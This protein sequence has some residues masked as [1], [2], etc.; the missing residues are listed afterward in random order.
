MTLNS[1][2]VRSFSEADLYLGSKQSRPAGNN[3]RLERD[4]HG[5]I[6]VKYHGNIVV[7][8]YRENQVVGGPV[9]TLTSA[10]W[11]TLT[12]KERINAFGPEGFHV[13]QERGAW[14]LRNYRT[15]K[16]WV[17]AD[18]ITI[19]TFGNVYNAGAESDVL[20]VRKLTQQIKQYCVAYAKAL[21]DG[22][23]ERPG[24]GDCFYCQGHLPGKD[25]LQSHM[26][27]GY[28]VPSLL[29]LVLVHNPSKFCLFAQ[30][31]IQ[32]L[33]NGETLERFQAN[34][35]KRDVTA[36]LVAYFKHEFEIA[37]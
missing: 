20:A 34:I 18:G 19:D 25:H 3:T 6:A 4:G 5:E 2:R 31:G 27:E 21:V 12:T 13:Y 28:L 36:A 30:Y 23:I 15:G 17:F 32:G 37:A 10:G 1:A 26:E 35:V 11:R 16:Q 7:T 8:Y 33:R 14:Y 24:A 22:K 29:D 9:T